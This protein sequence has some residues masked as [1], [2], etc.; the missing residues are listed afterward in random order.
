MTLIPAFR[1]FSR[2]S[3]ERGSGLTLGYAGSCQNIEKEAKLYVSA[4]R[5]Y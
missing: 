1:L 4:I 3:L 5:R 2:E